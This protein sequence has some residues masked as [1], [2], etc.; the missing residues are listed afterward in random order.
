MSSTSPWRTARNGV[1]NVNF[2][3]EVSDCLT[4]TESLHHIIDDKSIDKEAFDWIFNTSIKT[5]LLLPAECITS[6]EIEEIRE[7]MKVGNNFTEYLEY[8]EPVLFL[9][10]HPFNFRFF[11]E[12]LEIASR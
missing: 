10:N 2:T 5:T 11:K 12:F 8:C 1:G 6:N 3:R 7:L 9:S 4:V